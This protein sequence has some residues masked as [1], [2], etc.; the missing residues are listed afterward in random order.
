[1]TKFLITDNYQSIAVANNNQI[2]LAWH[3]LRMLYE[4]KN[5]EWKW[6][7]PEEFDD[8]DWPSGIQFKF[9]NVYVSVV[10]GADHLSF[11]DF[12]KRDFIDY[13]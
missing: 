3:K 9:D 11:K 7:K 2:R 10:P 4:A 12:M 13:E 8:D 5:I 1:M 6:G